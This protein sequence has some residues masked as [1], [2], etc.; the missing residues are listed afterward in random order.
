MLVPFSSNWNKIDLPSFE[1]LGLLTLRSR[2]SVSTFASPLPEAKEM[3]N[4]SP[5]YQRILPLVTVL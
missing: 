4:F 2:F 5:A 3:A 1:N